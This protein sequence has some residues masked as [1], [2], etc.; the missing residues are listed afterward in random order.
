VMARIAWDPRIV[1]DDV[2]RTP[3]FNW[4][5][6]GYGVPALAFW[7]AGTI[8]RKRGDDLASRSADSA[9]IVFTALTANLEIRHLMNDGDIYRISSGLAE[10]GLQVSTWLAMTIGLE[11]VRART[12][13]IVHDWGACV[14]GI[15]AFIGVLISLGL[16]I[17]PVFTAEPVGG[18]FF[19]TILLG[20]GIPAVLLGIL[21]RTIRYTRPALAYRIAAVSAIALFIVYL[22]LEVRA[23]FVGPV[24][25]AKPISD[26]EHYTLS[27]VWLAFGVVLLLAGIALKSQPARFAS[28]AVVILTVAKVFLHDL[29]GV[30]G[31]Y[32]A[33]SFICLGLVLMGIGWL[34]QR[35]LFP[36]PRAEE[37]V[38]Q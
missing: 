24:I 31:V 12:G 18:M 21:A 34:Y 30:Q 28:A 32:R 8:L 2:G 16:N 17:N 33:L 29:A 13:S 5:L 19:N 1:G 35:L 22:T 15:L 20:Y 23:I 10:V 9:A 4:L 6:W 3:I 14:F 36:P 7:M 25:A 26:A 38:A 37:L 11:H 27:A